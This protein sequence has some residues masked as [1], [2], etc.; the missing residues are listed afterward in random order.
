MEID[1]SKIQ[2][3]I[4]TAKEEVEAARAL[5]VEGMISNTD[6]RDGIRKIAKD[7]FEDL[8]RLICRELAH[9]AIAT[10]LERHPE[11]L[12]AGGL[13]GPQVPTDDPPPESQA[14]RT[15]RQRFGPNEL[16][17]YLRDNPCKHKFTDPKDT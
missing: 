6:L 2:D 3:L 14:T 8:E 10:V 4:S 11:I 17:Q 16:R 9:M 5:Y 7:P 12:R 1:D 13:V 15:F